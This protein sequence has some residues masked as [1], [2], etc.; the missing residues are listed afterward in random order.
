MELRH[1]KHLKKNLLLSTLVLFSFV[2]AACSSKPTMYRWNEYEAITYDIY[3]NPG[4]ADTDTQIAKLTEEIGKTHAEGKRVA[5]GLHAHLAYMYFLKGN[6]SAAHQEF[7]REK[8][9]FPESEK[10][11]DGILERMNK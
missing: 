8:S 4:K 6:T 3:I 5:P 9:L 2:S 11:V 10:F 1:K 7:N